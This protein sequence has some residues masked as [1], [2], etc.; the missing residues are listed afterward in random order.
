MPAKQIAIYGG[1]GFA[2]EVAWLIQ[3][4]NSNKEVY[5]VVCFID[6]KIEAH[7]RLLNGI[8]VMGLET[9]AT[10]FPEACMVA[11]VGNPQ[12]RQLLTEKAMAAGFRFETIIHPLIARSPW[13]EMGPGTVICAGSVLTT[14]IVLGAHVQ[15]NLACTVGHDVIMGDYTTL[16]P[17]VHI[18][19]CVHLGKRVY[20]GTG[21]VVI[22]GTPDEP[23]L[24]GDDTVIGAAACVTKSLAAGLTV[25]GIPA[26]PMQRV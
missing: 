5:E 18:S 2:R 13:L 20:V 3:S 16:A 6:D 15:I 4:C 14:N 22:N 12:T 25:V 19:G 21:A 1:G 9:A 8:S 7:G 26:K 10:R 24:I 11:A 23:L 17:G